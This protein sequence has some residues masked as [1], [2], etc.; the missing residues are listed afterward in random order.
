M[1][2]SCVEC[3]ANAVPVEV[4]APTWLE[5]GC[6]IGI[7]YS[8]ILVLSNTGHCANSISCSVTCPPARGGGVAAET[9]YLIV[10]G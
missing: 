6:G 2:A 9:P 10:I 4:G 3:G 7:L 8:G 1:H 5:E